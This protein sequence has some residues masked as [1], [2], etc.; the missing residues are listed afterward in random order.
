MISLGDSL[1][2]D[3]EQLNRE[4]DYLLQKIE[5]YIALEADALVNEN[6]R[7]ARIYGAG[8]R[9]LDSRVTEIEQEMIAIRLRLN[10]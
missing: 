9:E 1:R 7:S 3:L 10:Q 8:W 6:Y 4:R 2:H 5:K